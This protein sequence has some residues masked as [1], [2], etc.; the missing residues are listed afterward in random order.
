MFTPGFV[1]AESQADIREST[2]EGKLEKS[3]VGRLYHED[4]LI[5]MKTRNVLHA[6]EAFSIDVGSP[7]SGKSTTDHLGLMKWGSELAV[8]PFISIGSSQQ[9]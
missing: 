5:L 8:I 1:V 4:R 9:G 6:N 3:A 7:E 2:V